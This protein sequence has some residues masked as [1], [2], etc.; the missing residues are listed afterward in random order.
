[1]LRQV[2]RNI[3]ERSHAF[4]SDTMRTTYNKAVRAQKRDLFTMMAKHNNKIKDNNNNNNNSMDKNIC[5]VLEIGAGS[6]ANLEFIPEDME[7]SLVA[8]EPNHFCR[9]YLEENLRRYKHVRLDH[10][11]TCGAESM[12]DI[13]SESVDCAVST[14][15]LCSVLDQKKVLDEIYR[16]LKPGACFYFMEHVVAPKGSIMNT[17]QQFLNPLNRVLFD[18]CNVT[19]EIMPCIQG[20]SFK[21]VNYERFNAR[22]EYACAMF[23]P[24]IT[25]YAVK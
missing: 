24:H 6:G 8:L 16:V 22:L 20:S 11:S 3:G 23:R 5:R 13:A 7:V 1:M 21:E 2:F 12:K 9:P 15:V 25:G 19:R 18:G 4:I 17:F 14:L 10:Y